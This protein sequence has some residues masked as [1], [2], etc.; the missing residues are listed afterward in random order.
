[1]KVLDGLKGRRLDEA[2]YL[3]YTHKRCPKCGQTKTVTSFYRKTTRTARGWA[4]DSECIDCRRSACREYG[5]N[6]KE[7]RNARLRAWRKANPEAAAAA[8]R[9]AH[10]RSKYGITEAEVDAL[11]EAQGG[12]CAVCGEATTRLFVDHDHVDGHV[13]GLLCQTCN[14]FLGWYENKADTILRFQAYLDA[15]R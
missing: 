12:C 6:N 3:T 11:R 10:L 7:A 15:T 4:W 8:D 14:T 13:R 2:E 1:M 5:A 9:R